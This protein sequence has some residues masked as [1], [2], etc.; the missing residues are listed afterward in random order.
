MQNLLY[1]QAELTHQ[2]KDLDEL[3]ERDKTDSNRGLY[4]MDWWSLAESS[5]DEE[6]REQWEKVLE[7][8]ATLKQYSNAI[9]L[10]P[11]TGCSSQAPALSP[12]LSLLR[13]PDLSC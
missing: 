8:R 10:F 1:L 3:V 12:S 11:L 2:E 4:T 6:G 9:L 7:I 5:D 13:I